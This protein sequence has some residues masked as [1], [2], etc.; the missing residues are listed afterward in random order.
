MSA[1][2]WEVAK[3]P[4][5]YGGMGWKTGL[6]TFGA[7]YL[8]SIAKNATSIEGI[9]PT[10]DAASIGKQE[11]SEW[12]R[13]HAGPGH[14]AAEM[15]NN[16][17]KSGA[18]RGFRSEDG[19]TLSVAQW[20]DRWRWDWIKDQLSENQSLHV[21]AHSGPGHHWVTLPP[22]LHKNWNMAALEWLAATRRR[23]GVDVT[24]VERQCGF[25]LWK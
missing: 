17:R 15:V 2:I 4:Q 21:M 23:L 22:L 25:C 19:H 9:V 5:K 11:V 24:P 18:V 10:W 12:L 3:L 16:I 1:Q 14:D 13:L 20:C 6:H 7:H 8:T